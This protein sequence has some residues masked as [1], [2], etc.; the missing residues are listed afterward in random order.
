MT[1]QARMPYAKPCSTN[2][3]RYRD[4]SFACTERGTRGGGGGGAAEGHR[5][6]Q[7]DTEAEPSRFS[8]LAT[9]TQ[10]FK[11]YLVM[12]GKLRVGDLVI[13]SGGFPIR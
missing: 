8:V 3:R 2:S 13:C 7:R 5:G 1:C 11:T 12:H 9:Q 10:T 4:Y 6:A